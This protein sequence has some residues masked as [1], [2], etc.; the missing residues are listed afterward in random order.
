MP[1]GRR[2][3]DPW[4]KKIPWNRK[5]QV[6]PVFL[7]GKFHGQRG[8]AGYCMPQAGANRDTVVKK[9]KVKFKETPSNR[10]CVVLWLITQLFLTLC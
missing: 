9:F 7:P 10:T 6:T 5:W 2:G 8:L 4:V 3:L 1:L